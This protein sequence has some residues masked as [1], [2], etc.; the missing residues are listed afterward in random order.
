MTIV[1]VEMLPINK[2][3][4]ILGCTWEVIY[5]FPVSCHD[6]LQYDCKLYNVKYDSLELKPSLGKNAAWGS[7]DTCNNDGKLFS[8]ANLMYLCNIAVCEA[9][10]EHFIVE[11]KQIVK[12][13]ALVNTELEDGI[14]YCID[15]CKTTHRDSCLA[16][17]MDMV[18]KR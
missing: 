16:V 10:Q 1:G 4:L 3:F 18:K 5:P 13:A 9:Y 11:A 17:M 14:I 15:Q 7:R 12:T 2:I 6:V 8:Y